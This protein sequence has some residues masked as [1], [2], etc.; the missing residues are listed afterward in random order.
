MKLAQTCSKCGGDR[1]RPGQG[2]CRSCHA[3]YMKEWRARQRTELESLREL[4]R[5]MGVKQN[6]KR[7]G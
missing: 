5:V 6:V 7:D 4:A 2:Y 3:E 1:D